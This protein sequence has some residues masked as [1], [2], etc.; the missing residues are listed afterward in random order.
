VEA[1]EDSREIKKLEIKPNCSLDPSIGSA[2]PFVFSSF[3]HGL[4]PA[5][6]RKFPVKGEGHGSIKVGIRNRDCWLVRTTLAM[7]ND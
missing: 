1:V 7:D 3:C 5:N 2:F 6:K 4:K